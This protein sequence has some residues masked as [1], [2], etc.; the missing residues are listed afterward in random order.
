VKRNLEIL[1]L[2]MIFFGTQAVADMG[3]SQFVNPMIGTAISR[4]ATTTTLNDSGITQPGPMVP[5]GMISWGPNTVSD[6]VGADKYDQDVGYNH[7]SH[8]LEGIVLTHLSGAGCPNGGELPILPF[9]GD[10][11]SAPVAFHHETENASAG[12]YEMALDNG[13]KLELTAKER[14]G[15]GRFVFSNLSKGKTY[16]LQFL[17]ANR[18]NP[19]SPGEIIHPANFQ[20]ADA[21]HFSGSVEAGDFCSSTNKYRL[22]FAGELSEA[23][24][25]PHF[26]QKLAKITYHSLTNGSAKLEL[27]IAISYVS[28]QGARE[29]LRVESESPSGRENFES[30]KQAASEKWDEVLG[31]IRIQS[32]DDHAKRIFYT[33]LYHSLLH[34]NISEDVD[35]QYRGYDHR[36]HTVEPGHHQYANYSGWD[37]YRSEI[38]L[39][40]ILFP[41]RANDM[42]KSLLNAADQ[43]G[44]LPQWALN[45]ANT[46]V[47][48]GDAGP[49]MMQDFYSFGA[50]QFDTEKAFGYMKKGATDPTASC[51][52]HP[53]RPGLKSYLEKGYVTADSLTG[54]EIEFGFVS[55]SLEY[56]AADFAISRFAKSIGK[57]AD[58]T[59]FD[60]LSHSWENLWDPSVKYIRSRDKDGEWKKPFFPNSNPVMKDPED[61]TSDL[62]Q[63]FV[64]GTSAQYSLMLPFDF[65]NLLKRMGTRAEVD[66]RLDHYFSRVNGGM[67][68]EYFN[69]GN[70]PA[71][72]QPWIYNWAGTPAKTQELV[73]RILDTAF[74]DSTDG[75]PGNDDLGATSSWYVF[76]A[77]GIYPSVPGEGG[78]SVHGPRFPKIEVSLE[79]GKK[80]LIERRGPGFYVKSLSVN[81]VDTEK[82]W[83]NWSELKNGGNLQFDLQDQSSEWGAQS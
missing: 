36:N 26:D 24:G 75:L 77:L 56:A 5:F 73:H 35:G 43:C 62:D 12:S 65:A 25:V 8:R 33:A 6:H 45:H 15:F 53:I 60:Q 52:G 4:T 19:P 13:V 9:V 40:T 69:I 72:S 44:G 47:M 48:I 31:K 58:A 76:A 68:S 70:E 79:N 23:G 46:A 80:I 49:I 63:G 38:Q 7:A 67:N 22:Y 14:T 29:N 17:H 41:S 83:L 11:S 20:F 10:A 61:P 78:F 2:L 39:L 28:V 21:K 66:T 37:V 32:D 57:N 55:T 3:L 18:A 59:H 1:P 54:Q 30:V 27:K 42:A 81:S 64:E 74:F 34:P 51:N 50:D 82:T 16:G 71:F